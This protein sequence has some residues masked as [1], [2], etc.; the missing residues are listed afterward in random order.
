MLLNL[1]QDFYWW[2]I[3]HRS[4]GIFS[5]VEDQRV[6]S[7]DG[8]SNAKQHVATNNNKEAFHLP[9]S[10]VFMLYC[11]LAIVEGKPNKHSFIPTGPEKVL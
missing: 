2:N 4:I 10:S 1:M 11:C 5:Y 8:N 3:L 6:S 7:T 9:L